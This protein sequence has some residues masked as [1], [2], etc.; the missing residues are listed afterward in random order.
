MLI[1]SVENGDKKMGVVANAQN[2]TTQQSKPVAEHNT[3]LAGQLALSQL[4][5]CKKSAACSCMQATLLY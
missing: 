3:P 2:N 4:R 5:R 1:G